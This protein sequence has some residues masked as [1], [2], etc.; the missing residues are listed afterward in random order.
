MHLL[1]WY[2]DVG[3]QLVNSCRWERGED[4]PNGFEPQG[5]GRK[6][7]QCCLHTRIGK[8]LMLRAGAHC[9][10]ASHFC[11]ALRA[12]FAALIDSAAFPQVKWF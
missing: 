8:Q 5:M 1:I 12:M 4:L 11:C 6:E 7:G 10:G 2:V 3:G 9:N